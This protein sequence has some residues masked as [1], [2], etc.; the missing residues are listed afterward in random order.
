[1]GEKK[2]FTI[3]EVS[4]MCNI[5]AKALRYYDKIGVI[6]PDYISEENGYRYY[7]WETLLKVPVLKYYKQ[8]DFKLEE[9]Q[10]LLSCSSYEIVRHSLHNKI[11]ELKVHI[12]ELQDSLISVCDWYDLI[13]EAQLVVQNRIQDISVRYLRSSVHCYMDQKFEYDYKGSII[14]IPWTNYLEECNEKVT[15]PVVLSFPSFEEKRKGT[16]K[17]CRIL[18][19]AVCPNSNSAIQVREGAMMAA[20]VYHIGSHETIDQEYDRIQEWAKQRG[21]LCGPMCFERYVIDYWTTQDSNQFVTEI[22]VPLQVQNLPVRG[23]D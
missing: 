10:E 19:R 1:M 22:I 7:S 11:D 13:Q 14:N 15:G 17:Q 6:S 12:Q 9:M 23:K 4:K 5:S 18:Q 21:Y 8:M 3:G 2:F 20:S 16:C